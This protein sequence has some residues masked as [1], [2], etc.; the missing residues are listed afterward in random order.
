MG[1]DKCGEEKQPHLKNLFLH[2]A[3]TNIWSVEAEL[4]EILAQ[5]QKRYI[6]D[7]SRMPSA[8]LIPIYKK[9]GQ[10]HIVFIK[11]TETVKVHKGQI[12][13]PGGNRDT[14]DRTLLDTALR[15]A[16]EEIGLRLKDVEVLGELDDEIT[17]TSNYIVTP[18][19]A[20][21]P[22]PYRFS[23]NKDEVD[24]IIEVPIPALLDK[25]CLKADIETLDGIVVDSCT[26]HYRGK[27]IWGATARILNKLLDIVIQAMPEKQKTD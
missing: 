1:R 3:R 7:D 8:V 11:R 5:R 10:Y 27:V 25:D 14:D 21:I 19:V 2:S 18:F 24:E 26:Y 23:K 6:V 4:K 15:E 22:W 17:T 20:L 9:E 16:S 12:S 13:F